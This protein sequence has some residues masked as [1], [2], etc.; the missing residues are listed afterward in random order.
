MSSDEVRETGVEFVRKLDESEQRLLTE[1]FASCEPLMPPA[2][3]IYWL[4]LYL[5]RQHLVDHPRRDDLYA[6]VMRT[7]AELYRAWD[8]VHLL[9]YGFINNPAHS[10]KSQ[11]FHVDYSYTSSNLF[12][13]LTPITLLNS[14]HYLKNPLPNTP[15]DDLIAFGELEGI[16]DSEGLDFVEVAQIVCRPLSLIRLLPNTPHRGTRNQGDSDRMM[17]WVTVD[18]MYHDLQETQYFKEILD[19]LVVEDWD[20][21][22]EQAGDGRSLLG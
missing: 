13:P 6:W 14:F 20:R 8:E 19:P 18:Q 11:K 9:S 3:E 16:M 4:N 1:C 21:F 5:N 15:M 7:I 22:R 2:D 10:T 17:F 12:V